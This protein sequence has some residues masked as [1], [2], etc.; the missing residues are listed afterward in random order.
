MMV[1]LKNKVIGLPVMAAIVPVL[2]IFVLTYMAKGGVTKNIEDELATLARQNIARIAHAVHNTCEAT[3]KMIEKELDRQLRDGAGFFEGMGGLELTSETVTR[4]A[5]NQVTLKKKTVTLPK[6]LI[7]GMMDPATYVGV[8]KE[9][10]GGDYGIFQRMNEKGDMILV[11]ST[12]GSSKKHPTEG[13]YIPAV[14]DGVVNPIIKSILDKK[15]YN[16]LAY[17]VNGWH[18][19]ACS[20]IVDKE[21]KIIGMLYTGP[22]YKTPESLRQAI[23]DMKVGKTGYVY[24][25]GGKHLFH[26]GHYIVS[27]G[28]QRD[29]EDLWD[30]KDSEGRLYVQDIV[31]KAVVLKR[32]EVAYERYPW[33]NPGEENPR[34][35]VVALTYFEPWD[36]VI[37]A[38]VYMDDYYEAKQKV[39]NSM[40]QLLR[41][42][43]VSGLAVL[44]PVIGIAIFLGNRV[45]RPITGI[46]GVVKE[47]ATGDLSSAGVSARSLM[48]LEGKGD[49]VRKKDETG[50]LISSVRTMTGNLNSLVGQVQKSGILISSSSTEL[51]ATAREQE[52]TMANQVESTE[53][54]VKAM[55]EIST[56][57]EGLEETMREVAARSQETAVFASSGQNDL[58]RME[59]AMTNMETAS[60][61]ISGRL[62]TINEKAENITNVVVTI[63]KVAEQTNLLSLN[64]AIEAEKA[65]EYGR[66]FN[67]VAREIRRLADQTA[68]ATL[69]IEQMVKDMH[70]AVSAGVM[71]MDK[72]I[73]EVKRSSE[74]VGKISSQLARIIEQVQ[75]LSPSFE[76][77]NVAMVQQSGNAQK[78]NRSMAELSEEMK[79]TMSSVHETY[80]AIGQL[81]DAARGLHDE[82]SRFKV[83]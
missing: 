31:N 12:M 27:K 65:G 74:D 25:L 46:T 41:V 66:G 37:G 40:S 60:G 54:M 13:T 63:T 77:V 20:A 36:W 33:K 39:E 56:V 4:N 59:E 53:R 9:K 23:I 42:M 78:I 57:A 35:K 10:F 24:A 55:G 52:A 71:E 29:G 82:V 6:M 75:I 1:T 83:S 76:N 61:S 80:S 11:A 58:G 70:G 68:V 69:D 64:A 47:I 34:T 72:F 21:G 50:N 16:G 32:N 49:S 8:I 7:Y 18:F 73:S 22:L 19:S 28:G 44:I 48:G 17:I 51:A 5:V 26:R 67:V 38:S 2:V 30:S 81:N 15:I 45:T 79:E 43:M 3:S 14:Q 62:Q